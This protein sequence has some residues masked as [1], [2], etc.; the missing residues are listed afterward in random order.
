MLSTFCSQVKLGKCS[1]LRKGGVEEGVAN[2][3][4]RHVQN[5]Q[6]NRCTKAL[7]LSKTLKLDFYL[8]DGERD[9]QG[10][11]TEV[12]LQVSLEQR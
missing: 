4:P 5:C 2:Y 9:R 1:C 12:L 6:L 7:I 3:G 8:A 11:I 10:L